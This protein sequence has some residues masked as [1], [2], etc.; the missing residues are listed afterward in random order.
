MP[1]WELFLNL[2]PISIYVFTL[3]SKREDLMSVHEFYNCG[4]QWGEFSKAS[5]EAMSSSHITVMSVMIMVPFSPSQLHIQLVR[6][7]SAILFYRFKHK[8]TSPEKEETLFL[9]VVFVSLKVNGCYLQ[10]YLL[11]AHV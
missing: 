7:L 5:G 1:D 2:F 9:G 8:S 4:T 10:P 3:G 6:Q 11:A